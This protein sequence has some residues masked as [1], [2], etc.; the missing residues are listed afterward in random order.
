MLLL[1]IISYL[2]RINISF[3][4]LQMNHDLGFSEEIFGY[5]GGIFFIGYCIFGIPS[6][7]MVERI[8]ARRWICA[9]MLVWGTI[10]MLMATVNTQLTFFILRFLLGAAEAG[11]FPGMILYLTYWFPRRVQGKAVA[12]FMT[13]IPAAGILGGSLS[14]VVYQMNGFMGLAGWKWLFLVTGAPAVVLGILA[15]FYLVDRPQAATWL[16]AEEREWLVG[17][18]ASDQVS[19]SGA[20]G[21]TLYAL[22]TP[23]VWLFALL[24][25]C[26]TLGMYGFQLWLPRI[27]QNF[28]GLNESITALLC[29][30]PAIFQAL[31]MLIIA[32]SSDRT[33]ERRNHVCA[34]ALI[35]CLGFFA[36]AY[37]T[38][39]VIL[40]LALCVTAFGIWG[41]VGPFWAMP[42]SVLNKQAAAAGIALINSVGN[43][44]GFAGPALVGVIKQHLREFRYALLAMAISLLAAAF[45]ALLVGRAPSEKEK[46]K[47]SI[48]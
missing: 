22:T 15:Y 36:S 19:R 26:L 3:A 39:P 30:P 43:L 11:F 37:F 33:G 9:I 41:T 2:D 24:Y 38:Q 27:I 23:K 6:N 47:R 32:A 45:L 17:E 44:G 10:S 5:G 42:T 25:F 16:T 35:A 8:G 12:R 31:G 13:A 34:S 40:L 21:G 48:D 46:N 28:G 4:G 7:L 14:S 1:Y 18:L 20:S 29:I